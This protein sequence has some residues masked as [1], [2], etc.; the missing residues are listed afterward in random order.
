MD[1]YSWASAVGRIRVLEKRF[2]SKAELG[3]IASSATMESALGALRDTPYG[4]YVARAADAASYDEALQEALLFE[5]E[6]IEE[7]SPESALIRAYRARHDFHNVKVAA[8]VARLQMADN[9]Q[10]Y[11]KVGSLQPEALKEMLAAPPDGDQLS[12]ALFGAYREA[13]SPDDGEADISASLSALWMDASIDRAYYAY[14]AKIIRAYGYEELLA[15]VEKEIDLLNLR[16][17][18]RGRKQGIAPGLMFRVFLSSGTIPA[19]VLAAAYDGSGDSQSALRALYKGTPYYG[20]LSQ[21]A[22]LLSSRSSLTS[23]EKSCD[24]VLM[25]Y[26]RGARYRPLG[27]EPAYGYVFGKEVETRNLR[28]ILAGKQSLVPSKEITERLREPYV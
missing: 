3:Q 1:E 25:N 17:C 20:L 21:G 13:V 18:V 19:E 28:M 15:Y 22:E 5:Y 8:K 2:L 16:M 23:W 7:M 27:P 14:L 24:D 12:S 9:D 11:S 4:P 6:A 10:A 26:M